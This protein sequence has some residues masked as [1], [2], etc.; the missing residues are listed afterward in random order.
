MFAFLLLLFVLMVI[1]LWAQQAS[2]GFQSLPLSQ[3]APPSQAKPLLDAPKVTLPQ[4]PQPTSLPTAT[5]T[6]HQLPGEIPHA[7]YQQIAA[8]SPLPYQDTTLVKV[9]QQQVN[10]LLEMLKGFFGFEAQHIESRSDP[11]IQLPLTNARADLRTLQTSSDVLAR[12][13]G[14]PSNITLSQWNE[15][16]SN[17]AYLQEKVRLALNAS[18]EGFENVT[19]S[20][21]QQGAPA[22]TD[23]LIA[24]LDRIRGETLRLSAS[25]TTDPSIQA[26]VGAL[27]KMQNDV[28]NIV[29]KVRQGTIRELDIPILQSDIDKSLPVLAKPS[30]PLP[31]LLKA[32]KLPAGLANALPSNLQKDP[33]TT[34]LIG[35]MVDKYADQFLHGVKATL[36]VEYEPVSAQQSSVAN[37]GFPSSMDLQSVNGRAFQMVPQ[38]AKTTDLFAPTPM[39]AGRG[40]SHFDWEGRAKEIEAQI[41]K[42]GM[43]PKDFGVMPKGTKTSQEFSWRGYTRM[44]CTRL[45][46][47]FDPALPETCGC[48]PM[49]WKGWRSAQ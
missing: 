49:D 12:A 31:Q 20:H 30:E 22:T 34:R 44:M 7:P 9:N 32:A 15:I 8:M 45:M 18:S 33:D 38:P 11:T 6:A 40:P 26:R 3:Q 13:P 23:D 27:T 41:V 39:D 28:Q 35:E 10:S 4:I 43:D 48:P 46:A 21:A 25:G 2:E 5:P 14:I 36:R 29:D 1:F 47:S 17:L 19:S 16:S 37:T 24:F 42:R